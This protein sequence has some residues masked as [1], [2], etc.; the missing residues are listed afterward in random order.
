M[1]PRKVRFPRVYVRLPEQGHDEASA[2]LG[3]QFR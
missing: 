2:M 1:R 3:L